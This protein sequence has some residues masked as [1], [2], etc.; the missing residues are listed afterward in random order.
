[1]VPRNSSLSK[2][3]PLATS[4]VYTSK[5]YCIILKGIVQGVIQRVMYTIGLIG[6]FSEDR[7]TD[8]TDR[9]DVNSTKGRTGMFRFSISRKRL[10]YSCVI[11][12]VKN[13]LRRK[14]ELWAN[15]SG[16]MPSRGQKRALVK[17][18]GPRVSTRQYEQPRSLV[19]IKAYVWG[20]AALLYLSREESVLSP[21][22]VGCEI[23]NSVV[24]NIIFA[25]SGLWWWCFERAHTV[26][27]VSHV[28]CCV[29]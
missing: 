18:I 19:S 17:S 10:L 6:G 20:K 2:C 1:M 8:P 12:V 23:E 4:I 27:I 7:R 25:S 24:E 14:T 26:G 16:A 13:K 9:C 28:W 21:V 3:A 11:L 5:S 22:S 29:S 15:V